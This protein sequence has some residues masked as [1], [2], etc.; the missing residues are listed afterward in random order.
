[1]RGGANTTLL[2][3]AGLAA[4]TVFFY[5][6]LLF[7]DHVYVFR[8]MY[9]MWFAY[10]HNVRTL[11]RWHWP[12]LWDPFA[13]LGRPFASDLVV[14]VFYPLNCVLRLL[15]EPNSLN[16]SIAVHHFIAAAGAFALLRYHNLSAMPAAIGALSFAFGGMTITPL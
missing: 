7:T 12:P 9:T 2:G 15:P 3:L 5:R 13:G 16:V 4:Y 1:M 11:A 8:D 6:D 14:A 10:E